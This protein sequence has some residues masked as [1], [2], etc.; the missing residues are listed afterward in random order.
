MHRKAIRLAAA[1]VV[2]LAAMSLHAD[3][4]PASA[5]SLNAWCSIPVFEGCPSVEDSQTMCTN[6]CE[7]GTVPRW[8]DGSQLWCSLPGE[9]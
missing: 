1:V 5:E 9:T 7:A 3:V 6:L 2:L 4:R 8:C